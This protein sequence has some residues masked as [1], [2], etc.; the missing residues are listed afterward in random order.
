MRAVIEENFRPE[1]WPA[2]RKELVE[3]FRREE[4][5]RIPDGWTA[6]HEL[7]QQ[8]RH[9]GAVCRRYRI[10]VTY[11]GRTMSFPFALWLPDGV[12]EPV[13]VTVLISNHGRTA[14]QAPA[15]D[16]EQ[17]EKL[18]PMLQNMLGSPERLEAVGRDMLA[19]GGKKALDIENDLDDG[20]WPVRKLLER[21]WGAAAFYASDLSPDNAEHWCTEGAGRLFVPADR[22][23]DGCG[24]LSLWAFGASRVLDVLRTVPQVDP[25]RISSRVTPAEERRRCGLPCRTS[26]SKLPSPTTP[27]AAAQR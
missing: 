9:P 3:L 19:P 23:E 20:Y 10:T 11:D 14:A 18:V 26:G 15:V 2:R 8:T 12:Q 25:A 16:P 13:P 5:G 1:D 6:G 17:M 7:E 22:P 24:C 27:G 4:Y 21:G